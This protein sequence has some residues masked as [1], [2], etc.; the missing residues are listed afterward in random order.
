MIKKKKKL[1]KIVI[2]AHTVWKYA[3]VNGSKAVDFFEYVHMPVDATKTTRDALSENTQ[4]QVLNVEHKMKTFALI[5][6]LAGLRRSE[7][8][9]L[10]WKDIDFEHNFISIT[11]HLDLDQE[12][13]LPGGK[14]INAIRN[15]PL[16][17]YLK[18][19]L[20]SIK[21]E[22]EDYVILSSTGKI[23]TKSAYNKAWK[24]YIK[25]FN[26]TFTSHCLRH[27]YA[28]ILFLQNVPEIE[29]MQY[30]GHASIQTTVNIYTDLKNFNKYSL[31]K[32]YQ[33]LLNNDFR[34]I[35]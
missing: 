25:C 22:D 23:Y 7:A 9:A 29:A 14:T 28:T 10:Q 4:F 26:E 21:G 27:T 30:L 16:C 3:I 11:K 20:L 18:D 5:S 8:L 17:Y 12:K 32:E 31:S 15:V 6:M 33:E 13:I 24:S 19:Y 2:Y 1:K 34:I 35:K